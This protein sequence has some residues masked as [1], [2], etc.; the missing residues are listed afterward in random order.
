MKAQ[1]LIFTNFYSPSVRTIQYE[2]IKHLRKTNNWFCYWFFLFLMA[3]P[4]LWLQ[5][6]VIVYPAEGNIKMDEGTVEIWL[7]FPFNPQL[8]TPR[9]WFPANIFCLDLPG[10]A[11]ENYM[12]LCVWIKPLKAKDG[13]LTYQR[14]IRCSLWIQGKGYGGPE[15]PIRGWQQNEIHRIGLSWCGDEFTLFDNNTQTWQKKFLEKLI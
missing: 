11:K 6:S 1:Q 14:A 5:A 7:S 15:I 4:G 2:R 10:N 9:D 12:L 3:W 13:T 8:E